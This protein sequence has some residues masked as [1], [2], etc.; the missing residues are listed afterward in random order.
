[1]V[2]RVGTRRSLE[3]RWCRQRH[4]IRVLGHPPFGEPSE[5][6]LAPALKTGGAGNGVRIETSGS[7]PDWTVNRSGLR[8]PFEAGWCVVRRMGIVTSAVR[9]IGVRNRSGDLRGLLN[10]WCLR[11]C[12]SSTRHSARSPSSYQRSV[13]HF[14]KVEGSVQLGQRAPASWRGFPTRDCKSRGAKSVGWM[15]TRFDSALSHHYGPVVQ[16]LG[17]APDKREIAGS[18][19]RGT[20]RLGV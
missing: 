5:Q 9:Q 4:E 13:R 2:N 15:P 8:L 17:R 1:M 16:R 6:A 20:T 7:P 11:A 19:P 10:R 18:T 14:G 3:T 12:V